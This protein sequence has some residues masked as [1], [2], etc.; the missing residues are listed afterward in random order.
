MKYKAI[1][2]IFLLLGLILFSIPTMADELDDLLGGGGSVSGGV[3]KTT[4][5]K[6]TTTST[7]GSDNYLV[8]D[9]LVKYFND[10]PAED[11]GIPNPFESLIKPPEPP[12]SAPSIARS[13]EAPKPL[14]LKLN[15][16]VINADIKIAL[17]EN[18]DKGESYEMAEGDK[19]SDF[20]VVEIDDDKVII[21]SYRLNMRRTLSIND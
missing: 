5:A 1:L 20:S 4:T 12:A 8:S 11:G 16:V 18:L 3:S 6:K 10:D 7:K 15:G 13:K 2:S 17:I 14:R 9:N 21:F 19:N